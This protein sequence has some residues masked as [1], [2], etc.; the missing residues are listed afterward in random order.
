MA[1]NPRP[2]TLNP[3]PLKLPNPDGYAILDF[4]S[5]ETADEAM[6]RLNGTSAS[7]LGVRVSGFRALGF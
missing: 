7:Q 3:K 4:D 6:E 1:L 2:Q 5:Q